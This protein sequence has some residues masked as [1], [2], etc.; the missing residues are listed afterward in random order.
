MMRIRSVDV[1]G[2]NAYAYQPRWNPAERREFLQKAEQKW[3]L[4][5]GCFMA[6]GRPNKVLVRENLG[7]LSHFCRKLTTLLNP[8]TQF[9]KRSMF[10]QRPRQSIRRGYGI[11]NRKVDAHPAYWGHGVRGVSDAEQPGS[12]PLAQT[13]DGNR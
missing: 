3:E 4:P 1:L 10:E 13:I 6:Q 12:R 11:L 2:A 9:V 5:D 8:A 7:S